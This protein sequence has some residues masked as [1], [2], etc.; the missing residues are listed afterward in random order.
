APT[1][2]VRAGGGAVEPGFHVTSRHCVVRL[3]AGVLL[4]GGGAAVVVH[5]RRR[6]FLGLAVRADAVD[7][8]G[9]AEPSA[10]RRGYPGDRLRSAARI[11][12]R[13]PLMRSADRG[14]QP[15]ASSRAYQ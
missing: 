2:V 13:R 5:P 14:G 8:G 15:P 10:D 4:A 9:V 3:P 6:I 7:L 1:P 12:V 11:A